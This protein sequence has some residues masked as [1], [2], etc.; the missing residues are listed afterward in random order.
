MRASRGGGPARRSVSRGI[1]RESLTARSPRTSRVLPHRCRG[2]V[3]RKC[4]L[5][6]ERFGSSRR[7]SARRPRRCFEDEFYRRMQHDFDP[8]AGQSDD[9]HGRRKPR[10]RHLQVDGRPAREPQRNRAVA[11]GARAWTIDALGIRIGWSKT[12][13]C[14]G[15]ENVAGSAADIGAP[16]ASMTMPKSSK[17]RS[18]RARSMGGGSSAPASS[19]SAGESDLDGAGSS[20]AG[21]VRSESSCVDGSFE[22]GDCSSSF[23]R[24]TNASSASVVRL[25]SARSRLL[26]EWLANFR[27][28]VSPK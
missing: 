7:G 15:Y 27:I 28:G 13:R 3:R 10:L 24:S 12:V 14:G 4:R 6:F 1:E 21:A 11:R 25:M 22:F 2:F 17:S 18:Q 9:Q 16:A 19:R 20:S 23:R 5:R 26:N 8:F